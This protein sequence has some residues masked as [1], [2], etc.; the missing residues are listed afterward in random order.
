MDDKFKE[1]LSLHQKWLNNEP[2][3]VRANLAGANL[4][5]ADLRRANLYNAYLVRAN[6]KGAN[7]VGAN[8]VWANLVDAN[9]AGANLAGANLEGADLRRANLYNAYLVRANLK[10]ANL[11][12][13]NLAWANLENA[14]L[15]SANLEWADLDGTNLFRANLFRA[16]LAWANLKG[17]NLDQAKLPDYQI[18]QDKVLVVYKKVCYDIV[19][20]LEIPVDAK[21]TA[22]LVGNKC[23]CDKAKVIGWMDINKDKDFRV[24]PQTFISKHSDKFEYKMGEYAV[25][26]DYDNDPRLEC[27]SGIHFF[28]DF[29][30]AKYY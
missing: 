1:M 21:R 17:A 23:R 19:L 22:S 20:K 26:P 14:N 27:T 11:E 28:M 13:A 25:E 15:E 3:G 18:P 2:D 6:L 8:L 12:R 5:G 10:G 24:E 4:E 29:D 7:L 30:S 9:L 16:N